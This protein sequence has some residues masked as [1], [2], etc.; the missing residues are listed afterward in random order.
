MQDVSSSAGPAPSPSEPATAAEASAGVPPVVSVLIISYNTREMTLDC[1]RSL[2]DQTDLPHEVLVV[3]NNSQDGSAAAIAA[4]FPE[5]S[6]DARQD[7]LGFAGGNNAAAARARGEYLL[8]L[9]PDTVV[10]DHAIDRLVAF[11]RARPDAGIWGGRTLFG[12][13]SLNPE[14]CWERM[15]VWNCFCRMAGLTAIF[16]TSGLF[17]SER[18]G[19]WQRDTERDVDIVQGCFLLITRE[20]W[21][22]LGGFDPAFFM[23]GEEAD[24]CL[25]ARMTLGARPRVTPRAT[26]IHYGGASETVRS[27]RM[28][29]LLTGKM[30]LID[31]HFP[32]WQRPFG[33]LFFGLF[34]LTRLIATR[35]AGALTGRQSVKDSAAIWGDVWK[36]REVWRAGY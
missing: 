9:N 11:A 6:L 27:D 13:L 2:H 31:R 22:R 17:S 19:G 33:R 3:D 21:N 23:Y 16:P 15:T 10:L 35:A 4:E 32:P 29:K 26:I 1:L 14:S 18:Y 8:L 24:L 34:P 25:R 36:R 5:L 30:A 20:M 28:V 12:D 7:N